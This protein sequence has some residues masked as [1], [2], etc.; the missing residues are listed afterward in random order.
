MKITSCSSQNKWTTLLFIVCILGFALAACSPKEPLLPPFPFYST[1]QLSGQENATGRATPLS[2]EDISFKNLTI[3]NGLSQS[4]VL[5]IFQDNLGYLW[6]CTYEGA[7]RFDGYEFVNFNHDPQNPNSLR[8]NLVTAIVEDSQGNLWFGTQIGLDVYDPE[9]GEIRHI[10]LDSAETVLITSLLADRDGNLWV[11]SHQGVFHLETENG[12]IL[13]ITHFDLLDVGGSRVNENIVGAIFQDSLGTIWVGANLGLG[14]YEPQTDSFTWVLTKAVMAE[15]AV[16]TSIV[17]IEPGELLLGGGYGLLF[18]DVQRNI[19]TSISSDRVIYPSARRNF[20]MVWSIFR[21]E[22]GY[23]WLGT[24]IGLI[25]MEPD[26]KSGFFVPQIQEN[27]DTMET[28]VSVFQDREGNIWVGSRAHGL[29]IHQPLSRKF[30]PSEPYI[31]DEI[32]H[33]DI[34]GL[35]EDRQGYLWVGTDHELLKIDRIEHHIESY[36]YQSD[37]PESQIDSRVGAIIEGASG[38]LWFGT[39]TGSIY[40][41]DRGTDSFIRAFVESITPG[42]PIL[43][44][45]LDRDGDMWIG[46]AY[47]LYWHRKYQ[48][49]LSHFVSDYVDPGG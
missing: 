22:D 24:D 47:G 38:N 35:Y 43:L 46:T 48:G 11:G 29:F 3:K 4:S 41:Y 12:Q 30:R 17:E 8:D 21:A 33:D 19:T 49:S 28:V 14:R 44:F 15:S 6:F 42:Y 2:I 39:D 45:Y 1:N 7:D 5:C 32:R 16:T 40:F 26:L 23:F 13:N 25:R 31:Q 27:P 18:F 9:I 10:S 20:D 37:K 36:P 34:L